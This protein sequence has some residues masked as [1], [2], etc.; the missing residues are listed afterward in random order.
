M[1]LS[2]HVV[3]EAEDFRTKE[4]YIKDAV[5]ESDLANVSEVDLVVAMEEEETIFS[6]DNMIESCNVMT[7]HNWSCTHRMTSIKMNGTGYLRHK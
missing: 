5:K 2:L 3:E 6:V 4:E 1:K 7:Y